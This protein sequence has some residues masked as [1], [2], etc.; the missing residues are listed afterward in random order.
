MPSNLVPRT[1]SIRAPKQA[2]LVAQR[3]M[4][5]VLR[6]GRRPGDLLDSERTML[7]R[8]GAGR[9]TLREALRLLE[10]Q[11]VIQLKPGPGGGPVL[12]DPDASH[13]A[14]TLLLLLQLKQ[15]P[16]RSV[17]E[18]RLALEP[19]TS[20]LAATRMSADAL[21]RL[22]DTIDVMRRH[23]DDKEVFLEANKRFHDIVAW[24]SGNTLF[25]YIVNSMVDILDGTVMGIDYPAPRRRAIIKAHDDILQALAKR[26]PE[27]SEARMRDHV[28]EYVAYANRKFP[29]L[30]E[31]TIRWD[32]M[33]VGG[34]DGTHRL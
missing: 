23:L 11:G 1:A 19:M 24:S 25:G 34:S 13:L 2:M 12:Q 7:E 8:Y 10:F 9:G 26:D 5:D 22:S 28:K 20:R 15:T 6:E 30:L 27:S 14:N 4:R 18:V 31:R 29:E 16:F 32:R 21:D 33:I 3:I 17:V